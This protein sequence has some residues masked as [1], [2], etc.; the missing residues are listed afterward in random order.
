MVL[1]FSR[2]WNSNFRGPGYQ[3]WGSSMWR[4][5]ILK[6]I[7]CKSML[8]HFNQVKEL[9]LKDLLLRIFLKPKSVPTQ[10]FSDE[11]VSFN[12]ETAWKKSKYHPMLAFCFVYFLTL[13]SIFTSQQL[14]MLLLKSAHKTSHLPAGIF[15]LTPCRDDHGKK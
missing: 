9:Y 3:L 12:R 7:S 5:G 15:Q 6:Q 10:I 11:C 14:I 2:Y 8:N 13:S 1:I 4:Q